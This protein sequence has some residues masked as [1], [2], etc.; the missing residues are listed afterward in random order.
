[1]SVNVVGMMRTFAEYMQ[2]VQLLWN[3]LFFLN[4]FQV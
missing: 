2:R 4:I 1:M 3:C